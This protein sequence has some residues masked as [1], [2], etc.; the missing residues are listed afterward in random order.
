MSNSKGKFGRRLSVFV[1]VFLCMLMICVLPAQALTTIYLKKGQQ[2]N[3]TVPLTIYQLD[4]GLGYGLYN[5]HS[6]N[7]KVAKVTGVSPIGRIYAKKNGTTIVT[8]QCSSPYPGAYKAWKVVVGSKS[9]GADSSSG[10]ATT[11]K[12]VTVKSIK[13]NKSKI[14]LNK[15]KSATLKYTISPKKAKTTV[16]WS[17][18]NSSVASVN[19]GKVTAKKAGTATITAKTSN[20]KK[21]SC[22]VTVKAPATKVSISH[23]SMKLGRGDKF[24]LTAAVSPYDSTDKLK[25]ITSNKSIATVSSNG[26]VTVKKGGSVTITAKCGS[27]KATCKI[28]VAKNGIKKIIPTQ[29]GITVAKGKTAVLKYQFSPADAGGTLSWNSNKTG[30]AKVDKN[31]KVT[32]VGAGTAVITVKAS[33]GVSAKFTVKVTIPATDVEITKYVSKLEE[34]KSYQFKATA[35]PYNT[36][37]KISW[38][39]DDSSIAKVSYDGKVTAL[40]AGTTYIRAKAGGNSHGI[41]L[42]ITRKPESLTKLQWGTAPGRLKVGQKKQLTCY[43]YYGS[44]RVDVTSQATWYTYSS[45]PADAVVIYSNGVIEARKEGTLCVGVS[46]GGKTLSSYLE[47]IDGADIALGEVNIYDGYYTHYTEDG[48]T[49]TTYNPEKGIRIFSTYFAGKDCI[50]IRESTNVKLVLDDVRITEITDEG[51]TNLVIETQSNQINWIMGGGIYLD[52]SSN[53]T[54]Q[55]GGKLYTMNYGPSLRAGRIRVL[56]GEVVAKTQSEYGSAILAYEDFQI[57]NGAHVTDQC[58]LPNYGN[59]TEEEKALIA[60]GKLTIESNQ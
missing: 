40:K 7:S 53:I 1:I 9:S 58:Y 5:W 59:P 2:K 3:V 35:T 32:A 8:A 51:N 48:L 12:K 41:K 37:D 27:K 36:T 19:S 49:R 43:A 28:T 60:A 39:S 56:G 42:E 55:G 16:S 13:L 11:S 45:S 15:G 57:G 54:I 14:T 38:S 30:V 4:K 24:K 21:K 50:T 17:S 47:V 18:S 52:S 6:S 34:D 25:W 23:S 46:F 26:T 31:G 10:S 33:S 29:S 22:K 20:G 44:E